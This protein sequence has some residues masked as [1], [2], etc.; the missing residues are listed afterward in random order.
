MSS[1]TGPP[2]IPQ[3]TLF[4]SFI[5]SV[6]SCALFSHPYR[7]VRFLPNFALFL[8]E[9]PQNVKIF[10]PPHKPYPT[11]I[12]HILSDAITNSPPPRY[13]FSY[14]KPIEL[15]GSVVGGNSS[16]E[17]VISKIKGNRWYPSASR[18][19]GRG[20]W[21][22]NRGPGEGARE[23]ALPQGLCSGASPLRGGAGAGL[24]AARSPKLPRARARR[25]FGHVPGH[26]A[27]ALA[28]FRRFLFGAAAA[29]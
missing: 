13:T 12:H 4:V 16:Q 29:A 26:V 21:A 24:E 11:S 3:L 5:P 15:L 8:K 27:P 1:C 18:K 22:R 6:I 14:S 20:K 10:R 9:H 23:H 19:P 7:H 28:I 17:N 2:Q 25:Q